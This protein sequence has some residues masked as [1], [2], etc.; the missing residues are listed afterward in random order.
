MVKVQ[1]QEI[2][3][4]KQ[5][6]GKARQMDSF[7]S[8]LF[9]TDLYKRNQGRL[10]RQL[11]WLGAMMLV[12]YGC[13]KLSELLTNS[14]K[15]VQVGVPMLIAAVCGWVAFR[16]VNYPRFA[17]FLISVEAEMDKVS[18]ANWAELRRATAVV[19]GLMLFMGAYLFGIDNVW[20]FIFT[21]LGVLRS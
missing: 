13:Y 8:E 12:T 7:T 3:Q 6:A 16:A 1:E 19:V 5:K 15:P 18:W 17:N 20:F 10:T 2:T 4:S 9:K 21:K 14:G 11:T